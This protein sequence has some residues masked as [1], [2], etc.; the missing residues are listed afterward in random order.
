M[1]RLKLLKDL[2]RVFPNLN[3]FSSQVERDIVSSFQEQHF[4]AGETI[5]RQGD[6]C[7]QHM[8]IIEGVAKVFTRT[9][10]G[11]EIV[12]YRVRASEC[13][14]LT[15]SCLIG[16]TPFPVEGEAET[17][18]YA[19]SI[20]ARYFTQ[21]LDESENFRHFVLTSYTQRVSEMITIISQMA[22][23]KIDLRLGN[24]LLVYCLGSEPLKITHDDLAKELGT[25]REV[26][27]RNLNN[28][29]NNGWLK[30]GRGSITITDRTGLEK[31]TKTSLM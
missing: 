2:A 19:V 14:V 28:M 8:L 3:A 26:I 13:C 18:I 10:N 12:L 25:A 15:T 7:N 4:K 29:K 20:P 31:F 1:A 21:G 27:S 24:H 16:H 11:R 6:I 30:L 22:S 9:E 23:V 5:I 17:D